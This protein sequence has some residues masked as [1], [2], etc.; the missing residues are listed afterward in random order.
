MWWSSAAQQG[1][2]LRESVPGTSATGK[3]QGEHSMAST[4]I[5]SALWD[6]VWL[7]AASPGALGAL[8]MAHPVSQIPSAISNNTDVCMW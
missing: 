8:W 3:M 7:P 6:P 1:E 4:D 2:A 5:V